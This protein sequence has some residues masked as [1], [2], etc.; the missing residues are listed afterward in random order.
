MT[1]GVWITDK[2]SVK[3]PPRNFDPSPTLPNRSGYMLARMLTVCVVLIHAGC[4]GPN[5][6]S[7]S[8]LPDPVLIPRTRPPLRRAPIVR[9][10]ANVVRPPESYS[11]RRGLPARIDLPGGIR[12]PWQYIVIHH[13]ASESGNAREFDRYHRVV[14]GWNELGYHFVLGNG[15]G[16]PDGQIQ[17][18]PRWAKQKHGAHCKTPDNRYN[19][20]G[21]G[22]CLVGNFQSGGRPSEAQMRSL[23]NL[24]NYLMRT[25]NI[26]RQNI[27]THGGVTHKTECPGQNFSLGD[28]NARLGSMARR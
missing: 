21:I 1:S 11:L 16:A 6:R 26:S 24:V 19:D 25:C 28:L 18:G 9:D 12:R 13:S 27:L 4:A 22:I 23:A 2:F 15:R 7:A 5:S 17:V 14:L 3:G 20:Y 8:H 10:P